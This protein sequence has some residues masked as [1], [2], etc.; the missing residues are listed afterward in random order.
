MDVYVLAE[1]RSEFLDSLA[2]QIVTSVGCGTLIHMDITG[3]IEEVARSNDSKFDPATGEPIF[4]E[5]GKIMK[6]PA[7]TPPSL[8]RF[9]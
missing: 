3:A 2:D 6:G 7:Y 8:A 9:V 4:N 1:N 5:H